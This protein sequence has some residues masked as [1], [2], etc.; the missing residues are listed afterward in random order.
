VEGEALAR[1]KAIDINTDTGFLFHEFGNPFQAD[2]AG[3][4]R[5]AEFEDRDA[6]KVQNLGK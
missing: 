3:P 2:Q 5:H 1:V 4:S 6:R